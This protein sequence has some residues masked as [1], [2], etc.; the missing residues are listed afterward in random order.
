MMAN[1]TFGK[2]LGV[3]SNNGEP[4]TS[5][6]QDQ[7]NMRAERGRTSLDLQQAFIASVIY[8][9][10]ALR[11]SSFFVRSVL[12]NWGISNIL[13]RQTGLPFT[14]NIGTDPANTGTSK[15]PNRVGSGVL[16]NPSILH[17]FNAADFTVPQAYTFGNSGNNILSGPGL[18]NWDFALLRDFRFEA[19]RH[20][21][22][23]EFRAEFF[24]FTNH[25]NFG[26]PVTNI[27]S[28]TVGQVLSAASPR[29]IQFAL[30][31]LF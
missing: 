4:E 24:N 14:P 3:V 30:K 12:G 26:L 17:W 31:F 28:A 11:S 22:A 18:T 1:Y 27:Q 29:D 21:T 10:P 20:S 8:R 5:T 9:L 19:M 16:A 7:T 15:R 13:T 23:L 2:G 6:V 25:P